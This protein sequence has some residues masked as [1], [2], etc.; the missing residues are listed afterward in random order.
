MKRLISTF[1]SALT[2]IARG[3]TGAAFM[4]IIIAVVIQ[5]LGRSGVIAPLIWTE[6]LTRFALLW[7]A[8]CG[9][10]LALQS[11]DLVNVDIVSEALPGN[12]PWRLR[13]LGAAGT[14]IFA[15][16]LISPALFFTQIGTR[17][18]APALGIHMNW[19][20]VTSLVALVVLGLFA[21]LRVIGMITG[22]QDGLPLRQSEE[23]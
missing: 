23:T 22:T 5:L 4:V 13:M 10:G 19:V 3:A 7:L 11:G 21:T 14:A 16:A 1:T 15:F 17:Q 2:L 12:W 8:A 20:H 18:T 6:E 9:A